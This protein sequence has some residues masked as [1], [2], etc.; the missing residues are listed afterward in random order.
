MQWKM[1]GQARGGN[2]STSILTKAICVN[3]LL[4]AAIVE[5]IY[6][7]S[8]LIKIFESFRLFEPFLGNDE[9]MQKIS[10]YLRQQCSQ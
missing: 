3:Y 10:V 8:T 9:F 6:E 2:Q 5:H 7:D 1:N 4:Q